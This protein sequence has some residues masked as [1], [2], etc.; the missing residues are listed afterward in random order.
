M[1]LSFHCEYLWLT[2]AIISSSP[3]LSEAGVEGLRRKKSLVGERS[4]EVGESGCLGVR[5]C[6]YKCRRLPWEGQ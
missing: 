6:E 1:S 4:A 2:E 5:M 3:S